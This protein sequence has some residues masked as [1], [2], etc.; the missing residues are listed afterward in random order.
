M[1]H[2]QQNIKF[3]VTVSKGISS[4]YVAVDGWWEWFIVLR[5]LYNGAVLAA[6]LCPVDRRKGFANAPV[7]KHG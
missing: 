3:T 6:Q 2:G 4:V 1:I 5:R 7:T